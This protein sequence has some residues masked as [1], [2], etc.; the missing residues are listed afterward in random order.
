MI[1]SLMILGVAASVATWSTGQPPAPL[2]TAAEQLRLLQ[3]N[4]GLLQQLLRHSVTISDSDNTLD[5]AEACQ[6][7][8]RTVAGELRAATS[9][10]SSG[11]VEELADHLGT[12]WGDGLAPVL[13]NARREVRPGSPE[14]PRLQQLERQAVADVDKVTSELPDRASVGPGVRD[15]LAE[16]ERVGERLRGEK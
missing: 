2:P 13:A 3:S 8:A 9:D 10:T 12:V 7:A 11:R 1:R 14:Y 16:L 6:S 5:R 15:S 4:R